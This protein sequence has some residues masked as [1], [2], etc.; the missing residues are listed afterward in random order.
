[1]SPILPRLSIT[2]LQGPLLEY[3][4]EAAFAWVTQKAQ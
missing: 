2:P 1:M 3:Q 4:R